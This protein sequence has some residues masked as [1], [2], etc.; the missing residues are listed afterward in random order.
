MWKKALYGATAECAEILRQID[1]IDIT[2]EIRRDLLKFIKAPRG[3]RPVPICGQF[4]KRVER[5]LPLLTNIGF[6]I[7]YDRQAI[8]QF[9]QGGPG[10]RL[11][12][13]AF[14]TGSTE[15]NLRA[16]DRGPNIVS[17]LFSLLARPSTIP[18][19]ART[20]AGGS[21]LA[22]RH[23]DRERLIGRDQP[24]PDGRVSLRSVPAFTSRARHELRP[25]D[26]EANWE[27]NSPQ[28][29]D[30]RKRD[31]DRSRQRPHTGRCPRLGSDEM[32]GE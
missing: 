10:I 16:E 32:L 2:S 6:P 17:L 19:S 7:K 9:P 21:L 18:G 3:T 22:P 31:R 25:H 12:L 11:Q 14:R 20:G 1:R 26:A 24:A 15:G 5:V 23:L 29:G 8:N 28:V 13:F 30:R 4:E 27:R